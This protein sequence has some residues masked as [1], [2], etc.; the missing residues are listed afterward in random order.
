M[1]SCRV[2]FLPFMLRLSLIA[3]FRPFRTQKSNL[4]TQ[5]ICFTDRDVG[6]RGFSYYA[7]HTIMEI[8]RP[9]IFKKK[10]EDA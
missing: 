6:R 3:N 1:Y 4:T 8:T 2:R 9:H 10:R 7:D 5:N